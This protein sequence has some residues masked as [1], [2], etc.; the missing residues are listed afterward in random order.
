MTEIMKKDSYDKYIKILGLM[1]N[2]TAHDQSEKENEQMSRELFFWFLLEGQQRVLN[3]SQCA[4][5]ITG[6]ANP[7]SSDV[8][9]TPSKGS[10]AHT[11]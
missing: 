8:V 2:S 7:V 1:C 3:V 9:S 10:I 4:H 5:I 11:P 6:S